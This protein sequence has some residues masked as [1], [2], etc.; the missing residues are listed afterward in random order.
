MKFLRVLTF[1]VT[2][3]C[4]IFIFVYE[5]KIDNVNKNYNWKQDIEYSIEE[6]ISVYSQEDFQKIASF[7]RFMVLFG[8]IGIIN[9]FDY[10]IFSHI[11]ENSKI[12]ET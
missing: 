5:K 6:K 4:M 9:C 3:I 12:L 2:V 10:I 1:V 11:E 8:M 7:E